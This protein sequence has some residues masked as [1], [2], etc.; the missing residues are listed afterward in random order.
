[1]LIGFWYASEESKKAALKAFIIARVGDSALLAALA[2]L[3]LYMPDRTL[4]FV[5][6][7]NVFQN[8]GEAAAPA[9]TTAI[10]LLLILAAA[11]ITAQ[12]P[13]HGWLPDAARTPLAAIALIQG[14]GM[15]AL[16]VYLL[17][18]MMPLLEDSHGAMVTLSWVGGI[19]ALLAAIVAAVQRDIR[20]VLAY[21]TIS[22]MGHMLMA[23]GL[24]AQ[25]GAI[26]YLLT[27]ALFKPLLLLA[28]GNVISAA[29]TADIYEMGGLGRRMPVTAWTFGIGGLAMA[30]I[31]PLAGFWSRDAIASVAMDASTPLFLAGTGAAFCTA[32]YLTRLYFVVFAGPMRESAA[33]QG[34][35]PA[36]PQ[37]PA[38]AKPPVQPIKSPAQPAKPPAHSVKTPALPSAASAAGSAPGKPGF[39]AAMK[40]PLAALALLI[41]PVGLLETP[42]SGRLGTWLSGVY[43]APHGGVNAMI[44]SVAASALGIYLGW[45][46]YMKG[47]VRLRR[48]EIP[49]RAAWVV[50][51]LEQGFYIDAAIRIVIVRPLL[52]LG[53]LLHRFDSMAVEGAGA[54]TAE[55]AFAAGGLLHRL[56]GRRGPV[57]GFLAVIA[58]IMIAAALAGRRFW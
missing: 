11:G 18:R 3:F 44:V 24:G 7:Q 6:I 30:G 53:R 1:M 16:G 28:A 38:T 36:V 17:V 51:M 20:R 46:I 13:F 58:F 31:P 29:K 47:T 37:A 34:S 43:E 19:S 5:N 14:V 4:D 52:G 39:P 48:D 32:L 21:S 49:S 33:L 41:L 27:H 15:P 8:G 10:G 45:L 22:Q 23:L 2:L 35:V 26:F 57:Y 54:L 50:P 56:L 9:I 42:W 55:S 12:F 25:T 40:L